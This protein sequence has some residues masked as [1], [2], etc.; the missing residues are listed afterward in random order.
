MIEFKDWDFV[1]INPNYECIGKGKTRSELKRQ[2]PKCLIVA[3]CVWK[4][5]LMQKQETKKVN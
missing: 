4:L 5:F 2:Y 1:V 3:G